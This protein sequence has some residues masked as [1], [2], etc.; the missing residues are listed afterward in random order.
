MCKQIALLVLATA[1]L[2]LYG[3]T[4]EQDCPTLPAAHNVDDGVGYPAIV[5]GGV[6][7]IPFPADVGDKFAH[8]LMPGALRRVLRPGEYLTHSVWNLDL[9]PTLLSAVEMLDPFGKKIARQMERA[10]A[11]VEGE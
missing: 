6:T 7:G 3:S 10:F 9:L 1:F 8:E 11:A 5:E 2:P 4:V